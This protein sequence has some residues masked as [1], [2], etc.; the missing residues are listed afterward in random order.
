MDPASSKPERKAVAATPDEPISIAD[1][2]L[3]ELL[4]EDAVR[5]FDILYLQLE[6]ERERE[7]KRESETQR[8]CV[9]AD[10]RCDLFLYA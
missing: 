2:L 8:I 4:P 7:R 10:R 5:P 1:K 6:R 3:A 9:R